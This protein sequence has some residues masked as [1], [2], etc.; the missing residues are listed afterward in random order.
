VSDT[1][2]H[3]CES[4]TLALADTSYHTPPLL[5]IA[6][7]GGVDSSLLLYAAHR[8]REHTTTPVHALHVHHGLSPNADAWARHCEIEANKLKIPIT[9]SHVTVDNGA[10][11]SLEA[12][13]RDARYHVLHEY[14][15]THNGILCLG[16]HGEDQ[17][18]TVLL[19][20]KRGAGPQGLAGMG[21]KQWRN[22]VLSLRP[23][24]TLSKQAI[25]ECASLLGLSWVDDESN[26][27]NRYDRN[28][29]R[30]D[31]LPLLTQ[32]WPQLAK[33]VGRSAQ[34]LAEQNELI[35]A[36]ANDY[37]SQCLIN[38]ER[39]SC[40]GLSQLSQQWQRAVIRQWFSRQSVLL[41]TQA[42]LFQVQAMLEAQQDAN[43]EVRFSWGKLA[44][45]NG[46]LYWLPKRAVKLA[47]QKAIEPNEVTPIVWLGLTITIS[48]TLNNN[49]K[50]V[51]RTGVKGLRV[52]PQSERVSKPLK[53]WCKQ[54]KIPVWEREEIPVVFMNDVAV[55]FVVNNRL[56]ALSALPH[57]LT[58]TLA[59]YYARQ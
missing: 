11:K 23:M 14:C 27:D 34:L 47:A 1:I 8:F 9:V 38:N 43:P 16:Q 37:L 30:N 21:A 58:I 19:Q 5:V 33:T 26:A 15:Q 59:D 4:L 50:F 49:D 2:D 41:P 6:Y 56:V 39:I 20:L 22:G 52:K 46:Y 55:A 29:L 31:I 54:W 17:L 51:L 25:L 57:N 7:S 10:R 28:F 44:R 42:Q 36:Q 40:E 48:G 32:R 24:L 53:D 35:S 13:A 3:I 18:E 12:E 45:F